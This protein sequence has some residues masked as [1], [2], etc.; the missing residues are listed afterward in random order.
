MTALDEIGRYGGA[1]RLLPVT[2]QIEPGLAATRS[3]I[4]EQPFPVTASDDFP[5]RPPV[6]SAVALAW[7]LYLVCV[8]FNNRGG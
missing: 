6:N 7:G 3:P 1:A 2:L 8:N 4:V 5:G